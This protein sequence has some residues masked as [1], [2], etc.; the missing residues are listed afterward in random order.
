[1]AHA[2][3]G[4]HVD[5]VA[6][7]LLGGEVGGR[8]VEA[9]AQE[10]VGEQAVEA[11]AAPGLVLDILDGVDGVELVEVGDAGSRL[12]V[13]ARLTPRMRVSMASRFLSTSCCEARPETAAVAD[14]LS[15]DLRAVVSFSMVKCADRKFFRRSSLG[16]RSSGWS[17]LKREGKGSC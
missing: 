7:A 12:E 6:E 8:L 14:S 10:V 2:D 16:R 9:V 17:C 3:K 11:L 4:V 1:M 15:S 5:E 13:Q